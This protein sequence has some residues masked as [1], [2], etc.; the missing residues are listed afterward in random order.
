M[1]VT[2]CCYSALARYIT[3]RSLSS[4]AVPSSNG[5]EQTVSN[6]SRMLWRKRRATTLFVCRLQS[7]LITSHR[8]KTHPY[9]VIIIITNL[10]FLFLLIPSGTHRNNGDIIDIEKVQKRAVKL[11]ISLKSSI[12]VTSD[13]TYQL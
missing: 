11:V 8:P 9:T 12:Q 7:S 3:F 10:L 13:C 2:L 6:S 4:S 5:I 1:S